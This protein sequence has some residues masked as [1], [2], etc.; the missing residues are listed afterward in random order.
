MSL[1]Y[2]PCSE[3]LHLYAKKL[4]GG[5][6]MGETVADGTGVPGSLETDPPLVTLGVVLL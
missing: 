4:D 2:E 5:K 3:P 1:K 6:H